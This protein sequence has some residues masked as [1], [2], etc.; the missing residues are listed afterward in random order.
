MVGT[1]YRVQGAGY[2]GVRELPSL[3]RHSTHM[4]TVLGTIRLRSCRVRRL[5]TP[6]Q[7][8]K[9]QLHIA[10]NVFKPRFNPRIFLLCFR[11]S[12]DLLYIHKATENCRI[13][14]VLHTQGIIAQQLVA[15][16]DEFE[17]SGGH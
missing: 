17:R 7:S 16:L 5:D 10:V 15:P 8:Q 3:L 9:D 6:L 2:A 12:D 13:F 1:G 11:G 14:S 4:A